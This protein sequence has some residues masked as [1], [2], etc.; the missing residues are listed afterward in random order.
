MPATVLEA[1]HIDSEG[2]T[3]VQI[4]YV[5]PGAAL[6]ITN[7]EIVGSTSDSGKLSATIIAA[8]E[9]VATRG[10]LAT[11]ETG[12]AWIAGRF[13]V[14]KSTATALVQGH[15]AY[16]DAGNNV[17]TTNALAPGAD[18]F[19]LGMVVKNAST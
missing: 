13:R 12:Q 15:T 3:E 7:H 1:Q 16:W 5:N 9:D 6:S 18:D 2:P 8:S 11:D 14:P 19:A 10:T 4:T 17:A